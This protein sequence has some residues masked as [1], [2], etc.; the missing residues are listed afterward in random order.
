MDKMVKEGVSNKVEF[1]PSD[2]LSGIFIY[3]LMLDNTI[4]TGKIVYNGNN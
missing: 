4:Q 2:H 1:Q 3:R